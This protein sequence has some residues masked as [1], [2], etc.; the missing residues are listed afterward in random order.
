MCVK[1]AVKILYDKELRS[2]KLKQVDADNT[3]ICDCITNFFT[4]IFA[5][6]MYEQIKKC[7]T[8][9]MIF[10]KLPLLIN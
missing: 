3:K 8:S 5:F 10:K 2:L 1:N 6:I 9:F 7:P 4:V